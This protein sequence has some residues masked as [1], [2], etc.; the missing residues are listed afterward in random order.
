MDWTRILKA[1]RA[2]PIVPVLSVDRVE[3]A[4]PLA[5]ALAAGGITVS[6]ITLRTEAGLPS[7]AAFKAARPD[8]IVGAGTVLDIND[9]RRAR[10]GGSDFIVTPGFDAELLASLADC[11][12][13]VIPGIATASEAIA[14]RNAGLNRVKLFP[15]EIV[16]GAA[17]IRAFSGP[18]PDMGFM[19][20]G[21]VT[22][23]NLTE[24]LRQ[25][26]VFA[27]GGTWI[28]KGDHAS[29]GDWQAITARAREALEA[30]LEVRPRLS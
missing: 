16:G 13:P 20:T 14:A 6:E 18:L 17:A 27:V 7:I 29:S 25:E 15:A 3:H 8:M 4:Q 21:G 22:P 11:P 23:D 10:D 24:Y 30:A 1:L 9:L 2:C 19:P 5:N 28:A 26:T 12:I